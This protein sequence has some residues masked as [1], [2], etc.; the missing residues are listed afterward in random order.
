[1]KLVNSCSVQALINGLLLWKSGFDPRVVYVG[2]VVDI[3]AHG[4]VIL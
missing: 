1:M 2:C 4:H 3:I